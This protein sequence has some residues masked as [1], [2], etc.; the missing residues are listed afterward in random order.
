MTLPPP[1]SQPALSEPNVTVS[2]LNMKQCNDDLCSPPQTHVR[3]ICL[4]NMQCLR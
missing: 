3:Y 2:S 1:T 4:G